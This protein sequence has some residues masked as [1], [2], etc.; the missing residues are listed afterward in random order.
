MDRLERFE[1]PQ[2][3]LMKALTGWQAGMWTA[4]P[5]V[6]QTF[7]AS[8]MTCEV[9]ITVPIN[10][11]SP[12]DGST[13]WKN[14]PLL[15]DC[16]VIFPSGGGAT[17]TFPVKAGDEGLVIF[18]SRCIDAWWAYS[19]IQ[20]PPYIRM[21]NLSDGFFLPGVKSKPNVISNV[22]T[23]ETQLR[24]NDGN[25]VIGLNATSSTITL[26]ATT[27]NINGNV[28][29]TGTL[30]DNG[31]NVGSTHTHTGVTPGSGTSGAPT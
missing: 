31:K 19:K 11:K 21:H 17:L 4:M 28:A 13:I 15:R 7:D 22:S 26:K 20:P 3:A 12:E 6:V 9:Q 18:A 2:D 10:F 8:V 14:V 16:P 25:T 24:S 27:I 30:T 29:I 23:T 5:A 1:S